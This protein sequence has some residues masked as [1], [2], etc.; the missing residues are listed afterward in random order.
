MKIYIPDAVAELHLFYGSLV[1][2]YVKY[3]VIFQ[4][5]EAV[6][7]KHWE[8]MQNN[9]DGVVIEINNYHPGHLGRSLEELK[10]LNLTFADSLT[11]IANEF[12][13]S[14]WKEVEEL[15][16]QKYNTSFE[17]AIDNL[18]A[19]DIEALK[20]QNELSFNNKEKKL[21]E[22][23]GIEPKIRASV[24]RHNL[25]SFLLRK[26]ENNPRIKTKKSN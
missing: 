6:A 13:F 12:G 18:L 16:Q 8:G 25:D 10:G 19:G 2:D 4:H 9:N 15:G 7:I 20:L 11:T 21:M 14:G 22:M 5:L 1:T 24:Y 17:L 3:P 23:T 26:G